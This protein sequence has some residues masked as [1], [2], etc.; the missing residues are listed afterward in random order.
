MTCHPERSDSEVKDLMELSQTEIEC[1]AGLI[2]ARR[3]F[4]NYPK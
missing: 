2:A 1:I 3:F 4:P